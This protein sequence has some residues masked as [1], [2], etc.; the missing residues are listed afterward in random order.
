MRLG[1][2]IGGGGGVSLGI[3]VPRTGKRPRRR[4]CSRGGGGAAAAVGKCSK[5]RWRRRSILAWPGRSYIGPVL[6][7]PGRP[8]PA[9]ADFSRPDMLGREGRARW[10]PGGPGPGRQAGP[11]S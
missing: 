8:S 7:D 3:G 9:R 10:W 11:V 1:A 6:P 4:R 5:L 2:W